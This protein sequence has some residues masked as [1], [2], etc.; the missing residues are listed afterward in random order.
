MINR[1]NLPLRTRSRNLEKGLIFHKSYI[2]RYK[3][4]S[5]RRMIALVSLLSRRIAKKDAPKGLGV[6]FISMMFR[7]MDKG[8]I[9]KYLERKGSMQTNFWKVGRETEMGRV[10]L[11]LL[12]EPY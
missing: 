12:K 5:G 10:D 3:D 7:Y 9:T 8:R 1:N 11:E 4:L 6:K 2:F